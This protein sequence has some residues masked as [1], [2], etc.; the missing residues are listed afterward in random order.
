MLKAYA[1]GKNGPA[2]VSLEDGL[3]PPQT[4]WIDLIEPTREEDRLAE[5]FLGFSIPTL[6]EAQ[7]IEYSSR[8]YEEDG[9]IYMTA[10]I[11]AGV[12]EAKP[13]LTPMTFVIGNGKLATIR[14]REFR[15][16]GQFLARASKP[17]ANCTDAP[18]VVLGFLEAI[19]D[20]L[21]DVVERCSLDIDR[22]S[23]EIFRRPTTAKRRVTRLDSLVNDVGAAGDLVSKVRECLSSL[24]RLLQY[25]S[26]V[27]DDILGK[28]RN[29]NR[30]KLM[31]RDVRSL[32]DQ[33]TFL[34][35]KITFLLEATLG[36]I[37]TQQNE[38]IRVLTVVS[39]FFFPPTLIGTIYGMNFQNIPELSWS[40]GYPSAIGIMV[41]SALLPY[42]YFKRRGW[43]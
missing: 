14:Y 18:G 20:R 39:I 8:F 22:T 29:G 27:A 7:E 19:V 31:Q 12:E 30:V 1:I 16:L 24:E 40:L 35:S 6:E 2:S 43:L 34:N 37:S 5:A 17:G 3:I 33:I 41:L 28:G 42:L 11:V 38:V 13:E 21:A 15:A 10:S 25:A 36:L 9:G 4:V 26:A 23:Q 32:A